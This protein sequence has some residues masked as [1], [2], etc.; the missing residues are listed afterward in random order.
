MLFTLTISG[1]NCFAND[2][3]YVYWFL[4]W[5]TASCCEVLSCCLYCRNDDY[6][7]IM[8]HDIKVFAQQSFSTQNNTTLMHQVFDFI[9]IDLQIT[10]ARKTSTIMRILFVIE[11]LFPNHYLY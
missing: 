9:N 4:L 7:E 8:L 2:L 10:A 11:I 3:K 6:V 1:R 5:Y